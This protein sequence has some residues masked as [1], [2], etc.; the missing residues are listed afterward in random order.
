MTAEYLSKIFAT[1]Q[2]GDA[3]EESYYK[4]LAELISNFSMEKRN[5]K[6]DITILPKKTDAGNPDFR[7]W[8]GRQK[9]TG[10]IEAKDLDAD[11][12]RIEDSEQVQRYL[13]T[14]PNFILTNFTEFR[15]YRNGELIDKTSIA[16][17]F[18]IK[19]LSTL[20]PIENQDKF[21][22]LLE[23]F[24]DFSLPNTYTAKS[25]A[26]EL[27]KRTRFLDEVVREELKL[28]TPSIHSFYKVFKEYLIAGISEKDFA[29]IYSQTITY[30][31]FAARLRTNGDFNRKLAYDFIPK[32]IGILRDV[33]KFISLEDIPQQMEIIIDDI[34]EV[35]NVADVKK[36]L[37][38]YYREGK[39]S[40]PIL[41]FYETFLTEYDPAT[42]E[43]R[44]VYY[45][46]E[47]VISFIVRSVHQ[48]LK[49]KFGIFDGLSSEKVTL[50]D[51]AGGTL[52]FV[53]KSIEVAI[54]HLVKTESQGLINLMIREH[55]LQNFYAFELMMAPYAIGHMKISF[56]LE[57]QGYKMKDDERVKYYLT[58]TLDMKELE[59]SKFPGMLSLSAESHEAGKVKKEVPIL[60]IV[61]NPPYSGH[62]ENVGEWI[63][64]AIKDYY[65]V[66]GEPL[67]EKN[68][69]WLQDDYVK[70]IRFAQWKIDKAGEG[71]IGFITNHS[72]LDNPTFRGMR[73]SLMNSFNE[74]Y[75][76]DL[77][78][79]SLKKEKAPDGSK[80]ENVF[81]IKQGVA[82]SF[83]IKYKQKKTKTIYHYEIYGTR[84]I[85][86]DWLQKNH[87]K[88]VQWKKINPQPKYYLFAPMDEK[89]SSRYNSFQKVNEIFPVNSVGIVTARDNLTIR[90]S[91]EEV[92]NT[93]MSFIRMEPE[94][95]RRAFGLGSDAR[96][97]KVN[98]AQEDLKKSGPDKKNIKPIL[99]RPFDIRYTYYTGNSSGFHCRP[100]PEVM[101]HLLKEN[102]CLIT[103]RRSRSQDKWNFAFVSN[104]LVSGST[105]ISSLD[106]NY[107]F[108]L[109]LYREGQHK[110]RGSFI[111][112]MLFEPAETYFH[113]EP[114]IN[115][116]L[117][118]KLKENFKKEITP[119]EIFY[120][121]YAVLYSNVYRS[122]YAAL[123]K[124]DFPRIPF[125]KSYNL[126]SKLSL[127]GKELV[128]LHLLI[129]KELKNVKAKFPVL[130]NNKVEKVEFESSKSKSGKVWIN[131]N[132]YFEDINEQVWNYK[133]GGY[134]VCSKWL[135]DRKGKVLNKEEI[136]TYRKIGVAIQK[137][138]E[139]Q[140]EIDKYYK[141]IENSI[142]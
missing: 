101:Q 95:A 41:H 115:Q 72:F 57:E 104:N 138:M 85:K 45:T 142:K 137:T 117:I 8:D 121:I 61:G 127:S 102:L 108:P 3:R 124:L 28:G 83:F 33:F 71:I 29:D 69:K 51:P 67:G 22:E 89:L 36:I 27:A 94:N 31:L 20:P 52:G 60:V 93:V 133:I 5:K 40:D 14:F 64:E 111:Q 110:R 130:G 88:K 11:L 23:R 107:A 70:F 134:Q 55:F 39:G 123:L 132:Q 4:H 44:G 49:D 38:Q 6:V 50:L 19:K 63:S 9:I 53:A 54:E 42:R 26:V 96:D 86:Y 12:D 100:R 1:F 10:Y 56:L 74:I 2:K 84:E 59:E 103:I 25:L 80:D 24:L 82:I 43:K 91:E 106:I 13:L 125:P 73:R 136:I 113:R 97:W 68:P 7:I 37:E 87:I 35:L 109:Y 120:Y 76:L 90:W 30:G 99:Y 16:R 131:D 141:K 105:A 18:I 47:P 58:N 81:D 75:V 128:E 135:S 98:L 62:S 119:E 21:F 112:L 78:G 34:S 122:K 92:W 126:F 77:H 65:Q 46:P 48:I 114:N 118:F 79:N 129:S 66:D 15:L 32:S 17:P 116:E 140:K 139:L